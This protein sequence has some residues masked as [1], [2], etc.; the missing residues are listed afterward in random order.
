MPWRV[1]MPVL[2]PTDESTWAS[3][4]VGTW[5]KSTPRSSDARRRSPRD[6]RPRRRPAPPAWSCGRAGGPAARSSAGRRLANSC[7]SRRPARSPCLALMPALSNEAASRRA[8]SRRHGLVAHDRDLAA[9][10]AGAASIAGAVDQAGADGDVVGAA[11]RGRRGCGANSVAFMPASFVQGCRWARI[12]SITCSVVRSAG[13]A[14]EST[15][16]SASA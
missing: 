16:M 2:P 7:C 8:M 12:A 1:L 4:V 14:V 13:W 11:R 6:R 3:R 10:P 5:M 9:R 15:T